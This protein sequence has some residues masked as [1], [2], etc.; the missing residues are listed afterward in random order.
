MGEWYTSM[1]SKGVRFYCVSYAGRSVF[2]GLIT[3]P[4]TRKRAG[5]VDV[6]DSFPESRFILIGDTGEQDMK[7]Y[8]EL[9]RERP[10]QIH[11]VFLRDVETG[12][13]I[14]DPTGWKSLGIAGSKETPFDHALEGRYQTS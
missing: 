6:L 13:P 2:H 9:A 8:A 14:D 4:A 12:D 11:A 1:W 5:V 7:L 3:A 10:R